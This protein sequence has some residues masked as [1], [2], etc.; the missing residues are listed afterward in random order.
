MKIKWTSS[1]M[2]KCSDILWIWN[3]SIGSLIGQSTY[4]DT[5]REMNEDINELQKWDKQII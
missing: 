1:K 3:K 5:E 4:E 2:Q